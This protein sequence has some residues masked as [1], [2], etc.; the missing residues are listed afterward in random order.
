MEYLP[1]A[2]LV[3]GML[4]VWEILGRQ[5]IV[6]NYVAPQPTVVLQAI[7][8]N[9]PTFAENTW[10]T[11]K[12]VL[13]GSVIGFGIGFLL[14]VGIAYSRLLEETLYPIIIASQ[15]LPHIA[16]APILVV[17]LGFGMGPK[18][19][20]VAL[21]TFFPVTVATADGLRSV[22]PELLR[23]VR[24][25]GATEWQ[26]FSKI[27]LPSS[28]PGIFTGVK[29]SATYAVIAAIIG[30]WVGA[31][32][33]LG[34]MMLRANHMMYMDVVFGTVFIMSAL[35]IVMFLTAILL[36]RLIIPWH[37]ARTKRL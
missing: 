16:L 15:T 20:I 22:D 37:A 30:E 14:G 27:R 26:M 31:H 33:G 4:V 21:V 34:A 3:L 5:G 9:L 19:A 7:T 17:W 1:A 12:E 32:L 13:Y 10:M 24:S 6:Q 23:F 29:V 11:V 25:L 28:L 18:L 36:E 35:G 8:S 2:I